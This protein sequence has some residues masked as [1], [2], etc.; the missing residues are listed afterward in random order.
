MDGELNDSEQAVLYQEFPTFLRKLEQRAGGLMWFLGAGA[1]RAAGIKTAADMIW[2]FKT[3][4]Y[5][6]AKNVPASTVADVGDEYIRRKLQSHFD[7]QDGFPEADSEQEYSYYFE[8]TYPEAKDRNLYIKEAL[9]G[10]K[11][12]YGHSALAQL[13]KRDLVR[14]VWTT[15]FDRLVEDAAAAAYETT[16]IL[17]VGDLCEPAKVQRAYS[18]QNWPICAK[19]H[20]DF[21]SQS[22]KNTESELAT[23]DEAMRRVFVDTCKN[24]G[25]ILVGYS[26][27]DASILAAIR[28]AIDGGNGFPNGLFWFVRPQDKPYEAVSALIRDARG[29]GIDAAF[30]QT[31]SFDEFLSDV[32]RYLPSTEDVPIKLDD[33]RKLRPRA[34][35]LSNRSGSVPFVRSNAIPIVEY[36]KTA[37]LVDCKIGG[38]K[39]VREA[40]R[41]AGSE[42]VASRIRQGVLAFGDDVEIKRVFAAHNIR[43]LDMHSIAPERLVFESGE[44]SLLRDALFLGLAKHSGLD[45]V[46]RGPRS[47]F[48]ADAGEFKLGSKKL[49]RAAGAVSGRTGGGNVTWAECC[50]LRFDF[51]LDRLWVLLNPTIVLDLEEAEVTEAQAEEAKQFARE[52]RV[53]RY[54]KQV[55]A[56]LSGWCEAIF[57]PGNEALD[58]GIDGGTGIGARFEVM[59]VTG[60][61]GFAR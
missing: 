32:V 10:A 20:G 17:T 19:L 26:G 50:E 31:G 15:N 42:L 3:R 40:I 1:S 51:R 12:S 16:S 22:L 49:T 54:N 34:I 55:D 23:Q 9:K 7:A 2:D 6:S 43:G 57:G 52:R 36:P 59:P 14:V 35:D 25:L 21:H 30:V 18:E 48:R 27:R 41:S 33:K 47:L 11:P 38:L 29:S 37:R 53:Q 58:I 28:E 56:M 46:Q 5:R 4:L 60:F 8:A 24:Q 45:L 39:E 44:R 13:I 61:S